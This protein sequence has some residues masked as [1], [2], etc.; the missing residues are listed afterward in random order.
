MYRQSGWHT[1]ELE[2]R[3]EGTEE[4]FFE[5]S[6]DFKSELEAVKPR[7]KNRESVT[8]RKPELSFDWSL[9]YE[10]RSRRMSCTDTSVV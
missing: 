3:Q 6:G 4:F 9:F 7:A 5:V 8:D 1:A 10:I 2:E